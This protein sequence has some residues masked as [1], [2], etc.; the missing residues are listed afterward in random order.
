[1]NK[2]ENKLDSSLRISRE[3]K[4]SL[5]EIKIIREETYDSVIKRLAEFYKKNRELVK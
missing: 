3:T 4:D 2:T 5:D 1:M